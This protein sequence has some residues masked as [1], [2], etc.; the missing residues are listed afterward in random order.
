MHILDL[1]VVINEKTPVYPGDPATKIAPAG[2]LEA[3]GYNDHNISIGTHVGTHVDAPLHMLAHGKSL[4]QIPAERFIGRGKYVKVEGSFD[5]EAIKAAGLSAG[6][7]VVFHTGMSDYYYEEKYFH[8]Y[9]AMSEEVAQYLVGQKVS[10]VGFDTCS[11]DNADGFP[12]HKILLGGD[13]LIIENLTN[14]AVLEGKDFT[15][16]ALPLNL[17]IDGAPARVVAVVNS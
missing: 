2:V 9:P 13:V 12:I 5:L 11:A 8:D 14:L 4:D 6:D 1:S 10:M 16:Y 15:V 3:D 7:I 17:D